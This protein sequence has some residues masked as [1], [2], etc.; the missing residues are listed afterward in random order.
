LVDSTQTSK[1]PIAV[2]ITILATAGAIAFYSDDPAL[3]LACGSVVALAVGLLWH[4]GEP[5]VLL[6][7]AGL[8]LT[9]VVIRPLYAS[10]TGVPLEAVSLLHVGDVTSAIWFG[11]AAMLS[12]VV[13]MWCG[14][15]GK[16]PNIPTL[17]QLEARAWSPRAA[18]LFFLLTSLL[19]IAF[20]QIGEIS[21][22][23]RH[24]ALAASR[25]EWVGVFVVAFVCTV[26]RR[27]FSYVLLVALC[28][29]F[30]G[31][32]GF[33]SDFKDVFFVILVALA[34]ASPRLKPRIVLTGLLLSGVLLTLG[35]IWSAIKTD[36]REYVS[37][38]S[39]QQVVLVPLEDRFTN[40]ASRILGADEAMIRVGFDQMVK[41]VGYVDLLA[42]TMRNVP[43]FTP[44]EDGALIGATVMHVL[45]PRL[46]FPDKPPL[47]SDTE[48]AVRYSG[49]GLDAGGN[50]AETS[51]SLGYVAELY[52]DLGVIRTLAA[53]LMLGFVFGRSVKYLTSSAALPAIV[54]FG[55]ALMLMMAVA[56][57]E[58]ALAKMI[59]AFVT[60]FAVILALRTLLPYLLNK[61]GPRASLLN[62]YGPRAT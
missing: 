44:F 4:S 7:A 50:A 57:F 34:A 36:Y 53:M 60:A 42:A 55:L 13:G 11:L 26:Q 37:Q 51:I 39:M 19:S 16:R 22:G 56:S 1:R 62:K 29:V 33:Y 18:F 31:F 54:N 59:A 58:E 32:G 17:L 23:L 47:P 25:I 20:L 61:C 6:M 52:V 48:I 5:P 40:L 15:L 12:L 45:Q 8:Q 38:G 14:Q 35:A 28:E 41:R 30:K 43:A 46:L 10:L 49:V 27:G 2:S 3:I 21:G 24:P 9:Q